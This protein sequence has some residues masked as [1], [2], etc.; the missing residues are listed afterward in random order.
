MSSNA[1]SSRDRQRKV[2]RLV[3]D[4]NNAV[5]FPESMT[6]AAAAAEV[7]GLTEGG[8]L[9]MH[10]AVS[11]GAVSIDVHEPDARLEV[12]P[13]GRYPRCEQDNPQ[14]GRGED[15]KRR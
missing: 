7:E 9:P 15:N 12:V 4:W 14:K 10:P 8:D 6:G 3:R 11:P 2:Q 5:E 1:M 13:G